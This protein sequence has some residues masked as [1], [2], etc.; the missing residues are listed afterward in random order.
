MGINGWVFKCTAKQ[1]KGTFQTDVP[2][3]LKEGRH[4]GVQEAQKWVKAKPDYVRTV[5]QYK[6]YVAEQVKLVQRHNRGSNPLLI[7][8]FDRWSPEAKAVLTHTRRDS[9]VD[10]YMYDENVCVI[11]ERKEHEEQDAFTP[12]NWRRYTSNRELVRRELYPIIYNAFMDDR[13]YKPRPVTA[14]DG[15]IVCEQLILHGLPGQWQ[16]KRQH[17]VSFMDDPNVMYDEGVPVLTTRAR[18][19]PREEQQDDDLYNRVFC[20]TYHPTVQGTHRYQWDAATSD[21]GEADL[22]TVQYWHFFSNCHYVVYMDDGDSLPIALLHSFERLQYAKTFGSLQF[23]ICKSRKGRSGKESKRLKR[24]AKARDKW[25]SQDVTDESVLQKK[26]DGYGG[27]KT[28]EQIERE[29]AKYIYINVNELFLRIMADPR[30]RHVQNPVVF[31]ACAIIMSGTDYFGPSQATSFIPG[32]G[33]ERVV[34][35][36]LFNEAADFSHMFQSSI[37][38]AA[39]PLKWRT[40][41]VDKDAFVDFVHLCMIRANNA[42]SVEEV[43]ATQRKRESVRVKR[44]RTQMEKAKTPAQRAAEEQKLSKVTPKNQYLDD[45]RIRVYASHLQFN[46]D[47]KTNAYKPGLER[48]PDIYQEDDDGLPYYGFTRLTRSVADKVSTGFPFDVDDVYKRFLRKEHEIQHRREKRIKVSQ[49]V[50]AAGHD[51]FER[52][53]FDQ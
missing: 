20:I 30:L 7:V 29:R 18:I 3:T 47:Y 31:Y 9:G 36:T 2:G 16:Y 27:A 21:T 25:T 49:D 23:W 39:D 11:D 50:S 53:G 17:A 44:I 15:G 28:W 34:W 1:Y 8:C 32:V 24:H 45:D 41:V 37:E 35:P 42:S 51:I 14:A 22:A 12:E 33:V 43:K 26:V 19:T 38:V 52:E 6:R 40:I 46:A 4:C 10:K 5:A 13:Y 48:K